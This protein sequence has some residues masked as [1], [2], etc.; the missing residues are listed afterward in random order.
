MWP[1]LLRLILQQGSKQ[2]ASYLEARRQQRFGTAQVSGVPK[3]N[4]KIY[5]ATRKRVESSLQIC[6]PPPPPSFFN[7]DRFWFTLSGIFLGI[8]ISIVAGI[9]TRALKKQ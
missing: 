4:D 3:D 9:I 2:A 7:S 8:A 1:I 5:P 6:A